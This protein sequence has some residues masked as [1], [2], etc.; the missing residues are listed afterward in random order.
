MQ[1]ECNGLT[2]VYH[3]RRGA[4]SA[5]TDF[6]LSVSHGEFVCIVGPSG[7][8]KTTLI[9][10]VAGLTAPPSGDI[11]FEEAAHND[12]PRTALVFQQHALFAWQSVVDNV[13]FGLR[14]RGVGQEERRARATAALESVGLA[15]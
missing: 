2:K 7:C 8:G 10:L 3:T 6:S 13:A 9:K 15:A 11:R 14:M 1:F 12:R 4:L 5:L